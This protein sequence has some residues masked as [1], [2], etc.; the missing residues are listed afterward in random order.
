MESSCGKGFELF[1]FLLILFVNH[2]FCIE[3]GTNF[4]WNSTVTGSA[5]P[6]PLPVET[7]FKFPSPLPVI[8]LDGRNFGKGKIDLGDLEVI[9]VSISASTSQRVW[10]TYEGGPDSM[11]ISIFEP[12]NLPP[13]FFT[14]GFYAQPNNRLL[15]GW[16]LVA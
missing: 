1:C 5:H 4:N 3:G 9:Q 16:V 7:S 13:G 12:I 8:P 6:S 2:V 11:G 14:L 10:T 15:F